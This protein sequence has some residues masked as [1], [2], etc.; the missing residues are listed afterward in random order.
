MVILNPVLEIVFINR[1]DYT[2]TKL[3]S[4]LTTRSNKIF[5][6]IEKVVRLHGLRINE[7]NTRYINKHS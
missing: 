3:T 4:N 6:K 1:R 2:S 7:G 5:S